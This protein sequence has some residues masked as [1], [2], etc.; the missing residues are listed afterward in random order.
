MTEKGEEFGRS[1]SKEGRPL[2]A[3][4]EK[5]ILLDDAKKI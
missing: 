2:K 1:C 4:G 3:F 5:A